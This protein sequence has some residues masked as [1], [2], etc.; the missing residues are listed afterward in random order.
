[1]RIIPSL[2]SYPGVLA[3]YILGLGNKPSGMIPD[4]YYTVF[5]R[6]IP[7]RVWTTGI[8]LQKNLLKLYNNIIYYARRFL[9]QEDFPNPSRVFFFECT[10]VQITSTGISKMITEDQQ[11]QL[12]NTAYPYQHG[13]F[14]HPEFEEIMQQ[15]FD[16]LMVTFFRYL[17]CSYW[18]LICNLYEL[19]YVVAVLIN[20]PS[21]RQSLIWF[22]TYNTYNT[23]KSG[24]YN[25][26]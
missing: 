9:P 7:R 4:R 3:L 19:I 8:K 11:S 13:S 26:V 2:I 17:L 20:Q 21:N 22:D 16:K 1:M 14:G 6:M 15:V 10:S 25:T 24:E 5:V 12:Q 23:Y 18:V